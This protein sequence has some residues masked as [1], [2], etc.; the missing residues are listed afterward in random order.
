[1][2]F[3][4]GQDVGGSAAAPPS[5]ELAEWCKHKH[6]LTAHPTHLGLQPV[7]PFVWDRPQT[8]DNLERMVYE[9]MSTGRSGDLYGV[10]KVGR[11]TGM[12]EAHTPATCLV[13][14][15]LGA[16]VTQAQPLQARLGRQSCAA[17]W[18]LCSHKRCRCSALAAQPLACLRGAL[19]GGQPGPPLL[20]AC[21]LKALPTDTALLIPALPG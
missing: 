9:T 18:R 17:F 7:R 13:W 19:R 4:L 11:S 10:L 8:F 3:H 1:M 2:A 16:S 12:T 6:A 15:L 21:T 5:F 14:R 20:A